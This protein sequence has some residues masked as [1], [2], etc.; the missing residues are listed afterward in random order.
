VNNA[1]KKRV[2][3]VYKSFFAKTN[4]ENQKIIFIF[5]HKIVID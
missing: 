5:Q 2:Y 3:N 4:N 1:F